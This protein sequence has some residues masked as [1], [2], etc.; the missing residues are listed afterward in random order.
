MAA[1]EVPIG[2]CNC[3]RNEEAQR[4]CNVN[5]GSDVTWKGQDEHQCS[6]R[7][8]E[9]GRAFGLVK[10]TPLIRIPEAKE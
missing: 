2:P 8:N 9:Q 3:G 5:Q 7:D 10:R 4:R 1:D 6:S